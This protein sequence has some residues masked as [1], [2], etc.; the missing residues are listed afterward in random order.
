MSLGEGFGVGFRGVVG[1]G[2][3]VENKGKGKGVGR[4]GGG[5]GT[6]K[7][8]GKSMRKLCRNYPLANYPLVSPRNAIGRP[9]LAVSRFHAQLG[10]L[11]RL[12]LNRL[13]GSTGR[14]PDLLFL[15]VLN[16]LGLF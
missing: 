6:G 11:N 7:G 9:Y 14:C 3:P 13:G 5:V 1:G 8:T 4:V 10:V 12:A 16:L 15:G 2:F